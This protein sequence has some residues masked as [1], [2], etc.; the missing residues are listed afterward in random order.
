[1]NTLCK[2]VF[3][4]A[5][6]LIASVP[7]SLAQGTYTHMDVPGAV[8]SWTESVLFSFGG[9]ALPFSGVIAD[10]A[11]N[12]Y[13][14]TIA[15]G[16]YDHG[17]VFELSPAGGVWTQ[18]F[19]YS[20]SGGVDGEIPYQGLTLEAQ[21]DLFGTT[22]Y[23][24]THN[25]GTIF[26]LSKSDNG[27]TKSV[28][29]NFAGVADGGLPS[30][31]LIFDAAGK[32]YGTTS[33]GGAQGH[34]TVFQMYP[35]PDGHWKEIVLHSFT[36]KD[37]DQPS[38]GLTFDTAGNLYGTT[39][40]GGAH[41]YGTVF[42]L[43]PNDGGSWTMNVLHNF[44]GRRDGAYPQAGLILDEGGNLYGTTSA[45]G[46]AG[47]GIVFKLT[48]SGST[49]KETVLH[50][51]KGG[52]GSQPNGN[53]VLDTQGNLYGSTLQGGD[54]SCD[55]SGLGCGAVFKLVP[56]P[57]GWTASILHRFEGSDGQYA[58]GGVILDPVGNLYGTTF[59][60]GSSYSGVVFEVIP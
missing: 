18:T 60:G 40:V 42:Q 33:L 8:P 21:G 34:G 22:S 17:S 25:A 41:S 13:G 36:G 44:T 52:D 30:S 56:T 28:L 38:G 26:K 15:G 48:K 1:M 3:L 6:V 49:W 2:A 58:V 53:L 12:L 31:R 23:G 43:I 14:T 29:R 27:W 59:A 45:A 51:F 32:L 39:Y 5:A 55:S 16:T 54:N 11:G 46:S 47:F 20:F 7:L 57:N 37:G 50:T 9:S 24:G 35:A 4:L 19:L 10:T